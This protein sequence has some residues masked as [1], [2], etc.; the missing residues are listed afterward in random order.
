MRPRF[1][2]VG[3][4][5]ALLGACA[6]HSYY[7][8]V[9]ATPS[10]GPAAAI[11]C[12]RSTLT[13]LDY[14]PKSFDERDHRVTAQQI[15]DS[16]SRPEPQFRRLLNQI[17]VEAKPRADGKTGLTV[18]GHTVAEYFTHRGPTFVDEPSSDQV[19]EAVQT[20]V[21]ACGQP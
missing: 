11:E 18:N 17:E 13:K 21:Q 8:T 15:N 6:G 3:T 14:Q 4:L 2:P 19:K 12:T 10:A 16:V 1:V 7:T 5:A 9:T 20:I